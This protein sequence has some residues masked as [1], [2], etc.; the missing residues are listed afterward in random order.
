M[1]GRRPVLA[2]GALSAAG[3]AGCAPRVAA[4]APTEPDADRGADAMLAEVLDETGAPALAGA[5]VTPDGFAWRGVGGVRRAGSDDAAT[6]DDKWHLGSNTKAMTAALYARLV[7]DGR[8]RW[9]ATVPELF[10]DLEIDPAWRETTIEDL[11][12]HR[13]GLLDAAAMGLFFFFAARADTRP[14]PEQRTDVARAAVGGPPT[15]EPGAFVYGNANYILIGAAIERITGQS[16][17]EAIT[18]ELFAPL[19]ITSAGF[20]APTGAQ[21]WGHSSSAT[22][23]PTPVAPDAVLA[24]NPPVLGPAGTVHMA[25]DDYARFVRLFLTGGGDLLTTASMAALT[26]PPAGHDYALG[27]LA[28]NQA[29]AR[30]PVLAHEGSNTVWHAFVAVAPA[31]EMAI[32]TLSNDHGRGGPACTGLAQRLIGAYAPA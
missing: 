9:D 6:L 5:V 25:L 21:P 17:E 22:Q 14:L 13:A 20:G 31:R 7:Q 15:G 19:G 1:I 32:I 28:L 4:P 16:W 23:A 11:M 12:R 29:W 27:W 10:P 24:D 26:T 18:A 8:A 2:L 3:L 30:G